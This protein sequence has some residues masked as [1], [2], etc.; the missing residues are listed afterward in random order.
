M[1]SCDYPINMASPCERWDDRTVRL[2]GRGAV[3]RLSAAHV[4]VVGC[5]GVG[6]Y[7][8][9]MLARSGVGHLTIVDADCV[10][11]T[12]L[13]RQLIAL[14]H[15]IGRPKVQL[16]DERCRNIHPECRVEAVQDFVDPQNVDSLLDTGF[17]F[18]ADCIDTVAPKVALLTACK[19][20][21]IRVISS[22]GAGGRIDPTAVR[23]ADLWDTRQDG[24]ARAVR[25]AFKRMGR[26]PSI[27]VVYS[28]EA[29]R[30]A[31][32]IMEQGLE[33]KRSGYGTLATLP[34]I[35]G[36]YMASFIIR[37]LTGLK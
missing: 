4:L 34:S 20:R 36:I 1:N 3:D 2:L 14:H 6:G 5:G 19:Q 8:L 21:G 12:N 16:W 35:F 11:V 33:N 7:V 32:L 18:V 13:N 28:P 10:S 23:Y 31:S 25:A 29:P 26:R 27:P 17:D 22:M 30:A 37:K 15:D 9:E 24:L